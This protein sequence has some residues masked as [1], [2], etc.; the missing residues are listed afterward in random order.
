ML[1]V[2]VQVSWAKSVS[3]WVEAQQ[4]PRF[5]ASIS[6]QRVACVDKDL[7]LPELLKGQRYYWEQTVLS[8][9]G[10]KVLA[11]HKAGSYGSHERAS[12][13]TAPTTFAQILPSW[14]HTFLFVSH[15]QQAGFLTG[16]S[17]VCRQLEPVP[18]VTF[19]ILKQHSEVS[20]I[21]RMCVFT[22]HRGRPPFPPS[23]ADLSLLCTIQQPIAQWTN[24]AIR[25]QI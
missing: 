4:D 16:Y 12:F 23:P 25:Q 11:Q 22:W 6:G 2:I 17:A 8:Y 5:S 18:W 1:C 7:S 14:A 3:C 20:S 15:E 10:T 9:Y 21:S 24:Q 19:S 13:W